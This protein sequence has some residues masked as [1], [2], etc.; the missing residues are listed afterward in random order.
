MADWVYLF[1]LILLFILAFSDLIIGVSNDAVNFLSSAIGSKAGKFGIIMTM[2]SLGI[3]IG[4]VFSNGMMEVARKGIFHPEMYMFSDILL[5][6]AA[7]MLSDV[8]LLDFFNT[9]GLPTSTTVSLVFDLLGAAVGIAILKVAHDGGQVLAYI[10]S[11]KA[12]AIIGGILISVVIAFI[13]GTIVQW[14]A[15]LLFSFNLNKTYKKF[16]GLWTGLALAII[17]HFMFTKGFKNSVFSDEPFVIWIIHNQGLVLLIN[18]VF[19]TIISQ[20]LIWFTKFNVLKFTVLMGTFALAMAFASNDLVNFIG[21]PL[22]GYSS[23]QIWHTSGVDAAH[24]SMEALSG[25]VNVNPLFLIGAALVMIVTLW[26]SK[27]ARSVI[28]TSVNLSRQD[29]G[30]EKFGSTQVSRALVRWAIN[31]SEGIKKITPKPIQKFID[32]R[33]EYDRKQQ[34]SE[35]APAFDLVRASVN[36]VVASLLISFATSLKLPLSTTYVTFMVAMGTSLADKAWGRE[37]AVYRV[38]GVISVISGWFLTALIAFTVAMII[39]MILFELKLAALIVFVAFAAFLIY[40]SQLLHKK[41]EEKKQN[42]IKEA[43]DE[44]EENKKDLVE[45]ATK[46]LTREIDNI[47][48]FLEK[49]HIAFNEKNRRS[50]KEALQLAHQIKSNAKTL[51]KNIYST[52]KELSEENL[53]AVQYYVQVIDALREIANAIVFLAE[54]MYEHIENNHDL[55]QEQEMKELM[56]IKDDL[57]NYI[58]ECKIV[59]EYKNAEKVEELREIKNHLLIAIEK[60]KNKVLKKIRENKFDIINSN[61]YLNILAEYKN[62]ALFFIRIV[63]AHKRLCSAGKK[64]NS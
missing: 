61:L 11:G 3:L 31:I 49:V 50:L 32:K 17:T 13:V 6:F 52:V 58:L 60:L 8:L 15:R 63:K 57:Y 45:S 51:K 35:D 14:F 47:L 59:I 10:N 46:R 39:A 28:A 53:K 34:L 36:L 25:K 44:L 33:F 4:A 54:R 41:L 22:A 20:L 16:A 1:I 7:V 40:R 12:L 24:L 38:T 26:T 56:E 55:F 42:E 29:T 5:L 21:V 19:W 30:Y 2:A 27:K 18:F 23:Y 64:H 9:L 37:S 48:E 43:I 62:L